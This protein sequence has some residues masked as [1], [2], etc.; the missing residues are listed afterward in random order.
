MGVW[1]KLHGGTTLEQCIDTRGSEFEVNCAGSNIHATLKNVYIPGS[2]SMLH[3]CAI[4][5]GATGG[6]GEQRWAALGERNSYYM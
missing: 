1:K 5:R 4:V 3:E 2:L 6:K